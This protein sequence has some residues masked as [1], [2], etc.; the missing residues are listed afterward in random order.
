[1]N[2][3]EN[4]TGILEQPLSTNEKAM[5][6]HFSTIDSLVV[7]SEAL[8]L[9]R[10]CMMLPS[11]KCILEIGSYRGGSTVA[12]GRAAELNDARIFC[13]DKWSEYHEQSDFINMDKLKLNDMGILS[14]FIANTAFLKDRLF[15]LR[16][17]VNTFSEILSH[18][19]FSLVFIDGAHDYYSVVDDI[20]SSLKVIEPGGILCGHDYHS[21]GIDVKKAVHDVILQS[22]TILIKGLVSN[23]SIWYAVIEDPTYEL[24]LARTIKC[25][26]AGDFKSAYE[27]LA[28]GSTEV[29]QTAE[30]ARIRKGLEG[31]LAI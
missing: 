15:M 24:L 22:E 30:I 3:H 21:A 5:L 23:T 17:D 14:E 8:A 31:E 26:A 18:S 1:M 2:I 13:I 11:K 27:I 9:F 10:L 12:M 6:E 7:E 29:K 4:I 28:S 16:G 20:I 19:L 25:M